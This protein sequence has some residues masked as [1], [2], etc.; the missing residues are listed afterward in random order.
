[1]DVHVK[2]ITLKIVFADAFVLHKLSTP[3][4]HLSQFDTTAFAMCYQKN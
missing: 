4:M 3:T 1:M 2:V